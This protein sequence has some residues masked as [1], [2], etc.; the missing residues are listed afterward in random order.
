MRKFGFTTAIAMLVVLVAAPIAQACGFLVAANGAVRLG[1]TST[2]VAWEDGIERYITNFTFEGEVDSFGSL[3]PL[4]SEPTDVSRAGDWTLQRLQIEVQRED[5]FALR[6]LNVQFAA[7][8]VEV[9]LRTQIDSL[10][11]VVLKGG[12]VDVLAWVQD[13]GFNLPEGPS[14]AHLLEFYSSR[15]PYFLAARFD[16]DLAEQDGFAA[17]DGIPVQITM[18]TVR[19]WVPLHILHGAKPDS[20]NINADVYLL[21]PDRPDLLY[22]EGLTLEISELAD[23]LL[24]EDL[25]SDTGMEWIP[26]DGWFT[27]LVLDTPADNVVYDL[28]VGVEGSPPSF[29]D[30]GFTRF[31][32]TVDHFQAMGLQHE[33]TV[34]GGVWWFI[35]ASVLGGLFGGYLVRK[36]EPA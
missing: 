28:S 2:F 21:T 31:E 26:D 32:P 13:N 22:G 14:T 15:S 10:D 20:E 18:P 9:I 5:D 29:V 23:E 1:R 35:G 17:G 24:L 6:G 30:A 12:G 25:R 34:P 8:E 7:S 19:P 36:Q 33:Q 27:Y 16:A 4:P 3:I 11:V